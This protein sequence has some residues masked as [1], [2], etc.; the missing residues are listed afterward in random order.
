MVLLQY[1]RFLVLRGLESLL[2]LIPLGLCWLLGGLM[3]RAAYLA[4]P[5]R[6]R[7]VHRNVRLAFEAEM[8]KRECR[9]IARRHFACLG[10][11][12]LCGL[13]LARMRS[14]AVEKRVRYENRQA[15]LERV[16]EG[17]GVIAAWVGMGPAELFFLAAVLG[18]GVESGLLHEEH[19]N[20]FWERRF[21]RSRLRDGV[22]LFPL[23]RELSSPMQHLREGGGLGILIDRTTSE[24]GVWTPLFGRLTLSSGLAA[25]LSLRTGAAIVP[26]GV[27]SAGIA[28]WRIC[29][30]TPVIC[31]R[32][33][34]IEE[35]DAARTT[36]Q[37]A[38]SLEQLI[39]RAPEEWFWMRDRWK[40]PAPEFLL[41]GQ[42]WPVEYP[43][44]MDNAPLKPFRILVR[45][46]NWLGDAC[47]AVPAVRALKKG[48][49]D[50]EIT[51]LCNDNLRELWEHVRHVDRVIPKPPKA[52]LLGVAARIAREGPW[53]AGVLFPNSPRSALEMKLGR[54]PLLIGYGGRGRSLLLNRR[55]VE[56][57]TSGPPEHHARRYLRIAEALGADGTDPKLFSARDHQPPFAGKWRIGLCPGAA[58]G[59]AKRWPVERYAK[60]VEKLHERLKGKVDWVIYGPNRLCDYVECSIP[61]ATSS[62]RFISRGCVVSQ[63][64]QYLCGSGAHI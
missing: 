51:V 54:V 9:R 18:P 32:N 31:P 34:G 42:G 27:Y 62:K 36:A 55:L 44:G 14:A 26:V 46:P 4:L 1:L 22:K 40:T 50:A 28:R 61:S 63:F 47:M 58:Y 10:R 20:R 37:L 8:G 64:H 5:G 43:P 15:I 21:A 3:G 11:N 41:S 59:D 30:G 60:V 38:A 24:E 53:D 2:V 39:R 29:Y 45:S 56:K 57:A 25:L 52:F 35:A 33:M 17:R 12:L 7:M 16:E 23:H 49:P 19:S 48:R 6:R 13:K